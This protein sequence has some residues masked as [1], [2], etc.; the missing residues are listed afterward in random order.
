MTRTLTVT[1]PG[2]SSALAIT[3]AG[4][5]V[6]DLQ[7][8]GFFRRTWSGTFE[9]HSVTLTPAGAIGRTLTLGGA[10]GT[11]VGQWNPSFFRTGGTA[12]I[13]GREFRCSASGLLWRHFRWQDADGISIL[14]LHVGGLL[15]TSY[16]I[17]VADAF[18]NDSS[19]AVLG[20]LGIV[21]AKRANGADGGASAGAAAS[22]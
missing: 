17:E 11:V 3:E 21:V 2:W 15:R 22:G 14:L 13:A 1:R 19:L 20:L 9:G 10:D 18:E 12:T 16:S 7:G 8:S 4:R 6:G 5:P